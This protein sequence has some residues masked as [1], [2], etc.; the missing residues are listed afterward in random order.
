MER[1]S[2][3]AA[4]ELERLLPFAHHLVKGPSVRRSLPAGYGIRPGERALVA[5]DSYQ[6]PLVVEAVVQ[7]IREQG[8]RADLVVMDMGPDRELDELDEIRTFMG[9]TPWGKEPIE[10][11]PWA[12]EIEAVADRLSYDILIRGLGGPQPKT[13][14][15]YEGIPWIS[16]EIFSGGAVTFPYDLW[17][18]LQRKAWDIIWKNGRGSR[19]RVTD[20][21]GTDYS[22]TFL[23]EHFDKPRYGFTSEP[24]WGHLHGHPL[25]PYSEGEDTAGV[26]AGTLNHWGRP[27]PYIKVYVEKGQVQRIEGGG[28]YGDAW[29]QLLEATGNIKYPE[30]PRTGLFWLWE[31]AIGTNPKFFRPRN[32]LNRSRGMVYERLRSGIIHVGFGT[33]ILSPSEDWARAEG[34]PF[35]HIH[36]HL[37]FATYELTAKNGEKFKIIDQGHLTSLDDPEVVSLA[38]KYG[39]PKA[40]LKEAWI[41]EIPGV[42]VEGDYWKEYAPD[43]AAWIKAHEAM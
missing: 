10:P 6:D 9:H 39:D 16:R 32:V 19:V 5:V 30:Y 37:N 15:R 24:F 14:Y 42:S 41:P 18:L 8:A 38:A 35:G 2:P 43:P 13:R 11:P 7:A 21:E 4:S 17:D 29:R 31:T 12:K 27:F 20:P 1:Q 34:S 33:R 28:K 3:E 25:P 22:F 23:E 36:V 26:V 40:L